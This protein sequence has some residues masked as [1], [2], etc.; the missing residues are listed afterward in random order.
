M[1]KIGQSFTQSVNEIMRVCVCVD[2]RE[3]EQK[4]NITSVPPATP[5]EE[6]NTSLALFTYCPHRRDVLSRTLKKKH[7]RHI[8]TLSPEYKQTEETITTIPFTINAL[9]WT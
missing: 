9:S 6:L 4:K 8:Q 3:I 1:H 7:T 5:S 2:E